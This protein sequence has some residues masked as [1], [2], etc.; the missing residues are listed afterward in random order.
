[1]TS[2]GWKT[3]KYI[4]QFFC[5]AATL[6][7]AVYGISVFLQDK[8]VSVLEYKIY[9]SKPQYLYPSFSLYFRK[10]FIE[11]KLQKY[12]KDINSTT[13]SAFLRGEHMDER[14]LNI[15]YDEVTIDI[16]EFVVGYGILYANASYEYLNGTH[17]IERKGWKKPH[18]GYRSYDSKSFTVDIPF[19]N[20]TN[21]VEFSFG[22]RKEAFPGVNRPQTFVYDKDG[23]MVDGFEV[24]FHYPGQSIY[25]YA[26]ATGK[27][28]WPKLDEN[29][30][31]GTKD[32]IMDFTIRNI[33]V[34]KLRNKGSRKCY[35]NLNAHD[36]IILNQT[37]SHIG[38]VPPYLAIK[39]SWPVCK[40]KIKL[41]E[42]RNPTAEDTINLYD[43]PCRSISKIQFDFE[44][45][46]YPLESTGLY[47]IRLNMVDRTF[48]QIEQIAAF[49]FES[50]V[51]NVGGYLG[52]FL[53]YAVA[54]IPA[55]L[56]V[57]YISLKKWAVAHL[58]WRKNDVNQDMLVDNFQ[59]QQLDKQTKLDPIMKYILDSNAKI[60]AEIKDL[61]DQIQL[62][63]QRKRT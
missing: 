19:Q 4:Y 44:D 3:L 43:P 47:M 34:M 40:T 21:I 18:V 14:M 33:D 63:K 11:S 7:L 46:E 53:G 62:L 51:G 56:V 42:F 20:G 12:G 1:M 26:K 58:K 10:P 13:Y 54:E 45:I 48:K 8:D 32:I 29:K 17:E 6:A 23:K 31:N 22:I 38:C 28:T 57:A 30:I 2:V 37:I 25:S 36:S 27:W 61:K 16:N 55:S 49:N 60:F 52:L 35:E 9:N 41:A 59:L 15:S 24:M 5:I 50:L 39:S